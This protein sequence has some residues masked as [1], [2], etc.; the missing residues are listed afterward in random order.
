MLAKLPPDHTRIRAAVASSFTPANINRF[1]PLMRQ[2]VSDLLDEWEPKG[3]FEFAEFAANFPIR[4]MFALIGASPGQLPGILDPLETHG[5]SANLVRELLPALNKAME[6]LWNFVHKLIMERRQNGGGDDSDV[7]NTLIGAQASGQL[8]EEELH[9][10]LIFLFAAG[11]D[12]SKNM[13]TFLMYDML[14]HPDYW[15]R[16]AEDKAFCNKVVEETFRYHSVGAMYRTATEDVVYRDVQFPKGS[17]LYLALSIAA[18]DPKAFADA[19]LFNPE[20][21]DAYRHVGFGRGIHMCLGQ[22]LARAQIQEGVHM[23]AQRIKNPRLAGEI[24]W[25]PFPGVWGLRS[26]PVAFDRR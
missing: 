2:A 6:V 10:L 22:H 7:L 9:N 25:R 15:R 23:I 1:R 20:R 21:T 5:L 14:Q 16:C 3:A 18:R 8:S 12:T 4:I 19:D 26:L 17:V 13:L 11:Y 24:K